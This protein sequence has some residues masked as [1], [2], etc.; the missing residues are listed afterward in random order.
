MDSAKGYVFP[1]KDRH[2]KLRRELPVHSL[3]G[4]DTWNA[5]TQVVHPPIA[6]GDEAALMPPPALDS[7][8]QG[9][10]SGDSDPP[11]APPQAP[12]ETPVK[13]GH[14]WVNGR[15]V[16]NYKGSKRP[17][18]EWP[19]IW[20]MMTPAQR[21]KSREAY[22]KRIA[23]AQAGEGA[24]S[25]AAV[26]K[27]LRS[28]LPDDQLQNLEMRIAGV[29]ATPEFEVGDDHVPAMPV[30]FGSQEHRDKIA[31]S[32]IPWEA[33]VARPVG[34]QEI[35]KTPAAKAALQKEWDKLRK[36]HTWD[37]SGVREWHKVAAEAKA[38][39][40]TVHVGRIFSI[41]VEKGSELKPGDPGRKFKG[42]VV[43]QGNNFRDENSDYAIFNELSSAPASTQAAKAVDAYGLLPGHATMQTDAEAAYTQSKIGGTPTWVRL[44]KEQCPK[45]WV[46]GNFRDPVCP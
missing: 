32:P 19:E 22:D 1:L 5:P 13:A 31:L 9:Q 45:S 10:Q 18:A 29:I 44:P 46:E 36:I 11:V 26:L 35:E 30:T 39:N 42:R 12:V 33:C 24:P 40:T 14:T 25:A 37:E 28:F 7:A 8:P 23:E 34:K 27:A 3:E 38:S 21:T 43:F 15:W 17:P 41:C 6:G 2:D 4:G 16:R 20:G